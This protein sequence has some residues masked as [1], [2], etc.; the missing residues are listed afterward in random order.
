MAVALGVNAVIAIEILLLA[1]EGGG[2]LKNK[3]RPGPA[4]KSGGV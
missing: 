1:T 3:A 4:G 2:P